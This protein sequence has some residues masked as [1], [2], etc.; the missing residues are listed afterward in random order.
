MAIIY[1]VC[2]EGALVGSVINF[3]TGGTVQQRSYIEGDCTTVERSIELTITSSNPS[4]NEFDVT[5]GY[6]EEYLYDE[7]QEYQG[8]RKEMLM[9]I[10]AGATEVLFPSVLIYRSRLCRVPL[11]DGGS[12]SRD[13]EQAEYV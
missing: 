12:G 1:N 13:Q 5:L 3:F 11:V 7:V 4:D 10:P 2:Q 6:Y 9:P 8:R